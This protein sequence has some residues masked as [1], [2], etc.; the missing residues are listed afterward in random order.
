MAT[1]LTNDQWAAIRAAWEEDPTITYEG[2]AIRAAKE[3]GFRVPSKGRISQKVKAE[4]GWSKRGQ[5]SGINEAAQRLADKAKLNAEINSFSPERLAARSDSERLRAE[6]LTRH[7]QEWEELDE[8]R[9]AALDKMRACYQPSEDGSPNLAAR[10]E[11]AIAKIAAETAKINLNALEIKQAGERKSW[12]LDDPVAD[13]KGG[14]TRIVL[15]R[16]TEPL[17]THG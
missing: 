9:R 17:R 14:T 10:E 1:N 7:R 12:G 11:W 8:V 4:G 6:I 2:A 15:V 16:K 13:D 3:G 5:L